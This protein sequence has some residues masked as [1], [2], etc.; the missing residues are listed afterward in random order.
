MK[1]FAFN[2]CARGGATNSLSCPAD[3]SC[4]MIS[5]A[6]NVMQLLS[7]WMC[8]PYRPFGVV[9]TRTLGAHDRCLQSISFDLS[10]IILYSWQYAPEPPL[11]LQHTPTL[12]VAPDGALHQ[13]SI[14][15]RILLIALGGVLQ[16]LGACDGAA[17]SRR[18]RGHRRLLLLP[19][20]CFPFLLHPVASLVRRVARHQW[21]SCAAACCCLQL[22]QVGELCPC[23]RCRWL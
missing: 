21:R 11:H 9:P 22:Q 19:Q 13:V 18:A 8:R 4:D 5:P 1:F 20:V 12:P 14:D 3:V 7:L 23:K 17:H 2:G 15:V 10:F 16:R 6:R